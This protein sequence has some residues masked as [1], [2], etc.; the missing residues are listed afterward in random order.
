MGDMS[1]TSIGKGKVLS[2]DEFITS[3]EGGLEVPQTEEAPTSTE[4]TN[5]PGDLNIDSPEITDIQ[6][7]SNEEPENFINSE[8]NSIESLPQTEEESGNTIN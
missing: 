3:R 4:I 5:E 6:T 1:L 7:D 2:F 8:E